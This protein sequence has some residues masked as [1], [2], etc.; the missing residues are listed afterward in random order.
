MRGRKGGVEREREKKGGGER[1]ADIPAPYLGKNVIKST[2]RLH[3]RLY[4]GPRTDFDC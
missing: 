4:N 1:V 2:R 3:A